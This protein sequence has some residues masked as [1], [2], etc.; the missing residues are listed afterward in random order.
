MI[1]IK[2]PAS[3]SFVENPIL[4]EMKTTSA[5]MVTVEV[6]VSSFEF[7]LTCYPVK[8][9]TDDYRFWIDLSDLIRHKVAVSFDNTL[10]K[11]ENIPGFVYEY[12][13]EIG[14]YTF[15]GKAIPGGLS[16]YFRRYLTAKNTDAFSFRFMNSLEQFLFI[17][18]T[19][20]YV[21]N[22]TRDELM[23]VIFLSPSDDTFSVVSDKGNLQALSTSSA[24]IPVM[25][26]L[27]LLLATW[28]ASTPG[29]TEIIFRMNGANVFKFRLQEMQSEN[30]LVLKFTNSFGIDEKIMLT[31]KV[32]REPVVD[33]ENVYNRFDINM[34]DFQKSARR[35]NTT[36]I[37]SV[38]S[39]YKTTDEL[40]FLGDLLSRKEAWLIDGD[41]E[42]KCIVTS[43]NYRHALR[44]QLPETILMK[45]E[46]SDIEQHY[47]PI[48]NLGNDIEIL[49]NENNEI[50]ITEHGEFIGV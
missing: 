34:N 9:E 5:D 11:Q 47:T 20:N 29:I 22:I 39:G 46:I 16:K 33:E 8:V 13:V 49:A 4:F 37:I 40:Y 28:E 17:T 3:Y 32:Y 27:P 42:R 7:Q 35:G 15:T 41:V 6:S 25:V 31:G 43:E 36:E 2:E 23:P 21:I 1:A 45:I 14:A 30:S 12:T 50:I 19:D 26:N 38:E 24:G 48:G 44:K 18:R 10:L